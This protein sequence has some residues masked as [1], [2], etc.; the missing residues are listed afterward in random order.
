MNTKTPGNWI[1]I[2]VINLDT[3]RNRLAQE[4]C[5]SVYELLSIWKMIGLFH[6]SMYPG[7]ITHLF[8]KL[9][10][11][12]YPVMEEN[13]EQMETQKDEGEG[14]ESLQTADD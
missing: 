1:I 9:C 3:E 13:V 14:E 11:V 5:L 7:K 4:K 2:N 12:V 10:S 8:Q 6:H